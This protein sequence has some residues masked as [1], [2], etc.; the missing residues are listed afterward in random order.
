MPRCT[1]TSIA[2]A[3][4]VSVSTVSYVFRRDPKISAETASRILK[5]ADELGYRPNPS[6]SNLMA[7]IRSGRTVKTR[8]T[9]AFVWIESKRSQE[10]EVYNQQCL[11]GARQRAVELGFNL[12][13]FHLTAPG[14][15]ASRLSN[16]LRARGI[17]GIIFSSSE[18]EYGVNLDMNWGA[19]SMAII[20]NACWNPELHRAGH[21]HYMG[22]RR[23]MLELKMR[24]Y[25][26][27]MAMFSR[28]INERA[29]RSPEA[30][31]IAFHPSETQSRR[32]L[33][34]TSENSLGTMARLVRKHRPDS[35]ILT[36]AFEA[37]AA[38]ALLKR[39]APGIGVVCT[40]LDEA[41][42]DMTG[43]VPDHAQVAAN[44]M[45]LVQGQLYR[46]ERG[47]PQNPKEL[48]FEGRWNEGK[49]LRTRQVSALARVTL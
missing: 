11:K 39:S 18:N 42:P 1:L 40:Q 22:M 35:V 8:D 37:K 17:T 46:N 3:A 47:V 34:P 26:R 21:Y 2:L 41:H 6:V 33:F 31:F 15:T 48:L 4:R 24:G 5:I 38:E 7:H 10:N 45:D 36:Y 14:M 19:H 27:P 44:A 43:I 25:K 16:I 13:E 29:N 30:A 20:G 49:T 23:I 12:D 32:L 9:I 28:A